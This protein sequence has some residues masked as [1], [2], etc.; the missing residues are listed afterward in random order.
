MRALV[1]VKEVTSVTDDFEIEDNA[2]SDRF[3][4]YE[5]NE[6]DE[7]ALEEAVA[8]QEDGVVD[9]VV[10]VTVGPERAEETIRTAL[11]KGADRAIRVWDGELA[12]ADLLA[13]DAR[14]SILS[15][16]VER[17]DPDL[18][19]TGV[20]AKDDGFGAT[21]V[22]LAEEIGYPW[23]S[24][25]TG[26]ELDE[27]GA[28]IHRELEGGIEEIAN[29]DT[30]AVFTVQTGLNDP[31]Y[32]SLRGIRQAKDKEIARLS[33]SNLDLEGVSK[34]GTLNLREMYEPE[35]EGETE[36]IEGEPAEAA[37]TLADSMVEMG[38]VDR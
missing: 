26:L 8:L 4:E 20:Q 7:Y 37:A 18:I 3:T 23:S 34:A 9:E 14:V 32:A 21:G 16:V 35:A 13:V 2:I 25:V 38:G 12:A 10:T 19:F 22:M 17:E 11:A 1:A 29:V 36:Y 31:R 6:W 28:R 27:D 15:G 24:V 33:L 30:P 5:L